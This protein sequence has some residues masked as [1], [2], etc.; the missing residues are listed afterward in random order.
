[1]YRY[2]AST[3]FFFR[4]RDRPAV[5]HPAPISTAPASQAWRTFWLSSAAVFLVI[6]DSTAVVATYP[7]LRAYF[8]DVSAAD[9]SWTLNAYTVI[10]AALLVPAGRLADL[11]GRKRVFLQGLI[12]FTL[13]SAFCAWATGI[14]PLI[15]GRALQAIGASLMSPASLALI[16]SA[17]S[18]DRR[19]AAVGMFSA[20]GALAAAVGP[21]F[22]SWIIELASWRWIFLINLPLG[23]ILWLIAKRGLQESVSP[24]TGARLDWPGILM[25]SLGAG[26]VAWAIVLSDATHWP[27]AIIAFAAGLALL[28]AFRRWARGRRNAALDLTLFEDRSFLYVNIASAVFGIAFTAMFLTGFLFLTGVWGY[29][30]GQAGWAVTPGPLI[31]IPVSVLAG[32]LAGRIGHR[33]LLLVGAVLFAI[34]QAWLSL[35]ISKSPDYLAI[36]LPMQFVGGTG[37]GLV[38][39]SLS[40]AAVAAL[41]PTRLGAGSGVNNA[42]RQFGSAAGAALAVAVVGQVDASLLRYQQ[43]FAVLSCLGLLTLV[44]CLPVRSAKAN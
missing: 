1:M 34:S 26:A 33:P 36:W 25:L 20:S 30:Q 27:Q 12:L 31:S 2:Q 21:A 42:L 32:R 41:G 13:A 22:G 16:L 29:S 15:A 17:F 23:F 19:A 24:E 39:P 6:L 44:L 14:G 7:S 5:N 28:M 38:F 11:Q 18:R 37:I 10:Y 43:L 4:L 40:G 9:L 3:A 8:Q 35:S